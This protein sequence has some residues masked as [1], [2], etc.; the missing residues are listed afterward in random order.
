MAMGAAPV[1]AQQNKEEHQPQAA[2]SRGAAAPR[3]KGAM[4]K[5]YDVGEWMPALPQFKPYTAP[6][7]THPVE[8]LDLK[9]AAF[10]PMKDYFVSEVEGY[11]NVAVAGRYGFRLI[12]DDGSKLWIDGELVVD[13]DGLHGAEPRDGEIQLALGEHALR[14]RHF[15]ASAGEQLTLQWRKPGAAKDAFEVVGGESITHDPSHAPTTADGKKPII[16]SLRRGKPGDGT[17]VAGVHPSYTAEPQTAE[18]LG[19]EGIERHDV[20]DYLVFDSDTYAN[21]APGDSPY[22]WLPL[23]ESAL[24][25]RTPSRIASGPFEDQMLVALNPRGGLMRIFRDRLAVD[26]NACVFQFSNGLP[27]FIGALS[28]DA[29]GALY[30][31]GRNVDQPEIVKLTP[32]GKTA[33]EMLAVRAMAN[34][35]EIEF[36][37]PLDPRVG[38]ESE[39]YYVEFWPAFRTKDYRGPMRDGST[40][41]VKSASVSED[42]RRV[43]LELPSIEPGILYLRVLPPCV[44][45]DGSPL[46]STEAWYTLARPVTDRVGAVRTPPAQP[47]QN[48]L[49]DEEKAA[50]W[51]LLF[52]GKTTKGWHG[53]RKK[54]M[55]DGWQA[56]NGC[57]MR[58]GGGGDIVTDEDFDSFEL[59]LEWRIS[60]GGNSGIF[61]HVLEEPDAVWRTGPEMQVLDNSEHA[62]GR[63]PLT[64]AGSN[65]ALNA[66]ARDVTRPIGFF[67][68]ARLV[69]NGHHVEHWLNGEKLLEYELL[70]P[71]WEELVKKSKFAQMPRYGRETTGRIALQDHGDLV[72]YRNIKIRPLPGK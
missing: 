45:E 27:P 53:F 26:E 28:W 57:L 43:F 68:E 5:L 36:T 61:F 29:N 18:A 64:S 69:V 60:P 56:K 34:G 19:G 23:T 67:N 40:I 39:S 65:Y 51:H 55:P 21:A 4:L 9:G 7:A 14:I 31:G 35:A 22:A 20:M 37:K 72:W 1:L 59:K 17:P 58:V 2:K 47:P 16:P 52:D 25:A 15:D 3:A 13:A 62:D 71:A 46:W 12:S 24:R 33:F 44:A 49:T 6:N 66:P 32:N 42:R 70:S 63:N 41:P 8:T 30:V 10:A 54:E 38:W 11:L 48:F 50:G